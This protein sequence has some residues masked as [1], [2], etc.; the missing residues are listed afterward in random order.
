MTAI[1]T[2]DTKAQ[3]IILDAIKDHVI[4]IIGEK[5]CAYEM[6]D[7]LIKTFQSSNEN[8]KMVLKEK[9]KCIRMAKG[10][11]VTSYLTQIKQVKDEVAAVGEAV[12]ET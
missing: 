3:R 7:A 11:C 1:N 9:L 8:R 2:K 10:E 6:F 4:P 5:T 12:A